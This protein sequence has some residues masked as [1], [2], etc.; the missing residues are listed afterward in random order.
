MYLVQDE[1]EP[2]SARWLGMGRET[3]GVKERSFKGNLAYCRVSPRAN[4]LKAWKMG[5][6][7]AFMNHETE[8]ETIFQVALNATC[9]VSSKLS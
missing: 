5:T 3:S 4:F 2:L 7:S 6:T 9:P 1:S 8:I